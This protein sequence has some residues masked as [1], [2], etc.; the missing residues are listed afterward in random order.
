VSVFV[1]AG[2]EV[3]AG[4]TPASIESAELAQ[5]G[6]FGQPKVEEARKEVAAT[7]KVGDKAVGAVKEGTAQPESE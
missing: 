7:H 4:Q 2:E 5:L 6:V 1:V 3:R